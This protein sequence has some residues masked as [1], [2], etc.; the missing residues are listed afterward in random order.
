MLGESVS[1]CSLNSLE[2]S[3]F[4]GVL[5]LSADLIKAALSAPKKPF[6][7]PAVV[8]LGQQLPVRGR[9]E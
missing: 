5:Y 3:L 9:K 4:A 7:Q 8:A 2:K 1:T 6:A